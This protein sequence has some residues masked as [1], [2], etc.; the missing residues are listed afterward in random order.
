MANNHIFLSAGHSNMDP[1]AIGNGYK[2]ADLTKELRS[3]VACEIVKNP[4]INLTLDNDAQTSGETAN[5]IGLI[6]KEG[7]VLCDIHFNAGTPVATGTEV[8]IPEQNTPME[9]TIAGEL[10]HGI[11]VLLGIKDR[12]VKTEADS[13][14]KRLV[15]MR[16]KGRN[17]L[18]EVCFISNPTDIKSYQSKKNEVAKFIAQTLIKYAKK[19]A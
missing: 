11:A 17:L 9:R 12:G 8:L 3:L 4:D 15:F 19:A 18:I 10:S 7:D 6:S 14:R 16:P 13:A 5:K 2:E 1:G